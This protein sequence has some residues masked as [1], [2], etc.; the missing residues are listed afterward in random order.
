MTATLE[1]TTFTTSR[2]LE[3]F[4][5]RELRYQTGRAPHE[6]PAVVLKELMDNALDACEAAKVAPVIDVNV[7]CDE[8]R[9]TTSVAD[10]GPGIA[11]DVLERILDF[12]TRT[13]ST[14]HYVSPTRGA[15][16]NALKTILAMPYVTSMEE[17]KVGHIEVAS[18]GVRPPHH[19]DHRFAPAGTE[20]HARAGAW[21]NH[22][23]HPRHGKNGPPA[24]PA[25]FKYS[26]PQASPRTPTPSAGYASASTRGG[27]FV[28]LAPWRASR[29]SG[30]G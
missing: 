24:S 17:P 18:N 27:R 30:R 2:L 12:A 22:G 10:N 20:D 16:G 9:T 28:H 13:S 14:E 11:P 4:S 29:D 6:W 15:Q 19:R 26:W 23:R 21:R 25:L 1:R 5:D 8:E 3:Y 7:D